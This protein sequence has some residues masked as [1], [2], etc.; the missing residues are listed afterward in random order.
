[1]ATKA[2][3]PTVGVKTKQ[4]NG[5]MAKSNKMKTSTKLNTLDFTSKTPKKT[6]QK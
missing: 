1:M 5:T 3:K 4:G 6:G 2:K